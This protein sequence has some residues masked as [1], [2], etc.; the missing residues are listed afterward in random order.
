M[1]AKGLSFW[2]KHCADVSLPSFSQPSTYQVKLDTK[3]KNSYEELTQRFYQDPIIVFSLFHAANQ[4]INSANKSLKRFDHALS[5]LG[6]KKINL[7]LNKMNQ[8][9]FRPKNIWHQQYLRAT[10][11]CLH[12]AYQARETAHYLNGL[13]KEEAFLSSLLLGIPLCILWFHAIPEMR[14]IESLV[15]NEQEQWVDAQKKVLGCSLQELS[16]ALAEELHFPTLVQN[17]LNETHQ[18]S[19]KDLA[20]TRLSIQYQNMSRTFQRND[21]RSFRRISQSIPLAIGLSQ[22]FA[23]EAQWNWFSKRT[24]KAI[25]WYSAMT[26]KTVDQTIQWVHQISASAAQSYPIG[27][28]HHAA[29]KLLHENITPRYAL[30]IITIA[31]PIAPPQK[32]APEKTHKPSETDKSQVQNKGNTLPVETEDPRLSLKLM[33]QLEELSIPSSSKKTERISPLITSNTLELKDIIERPNDPSLMKTLQHQLIHN[34]TKLKSLQNIMNLLMKGVC[35][36][37][38]LPRA[39]GGFVDLANS[40]IVFSFG[41]GITP[42]QGLINFHTS[43]EKH[44]LFDLIIAKPAALWIKPDS[45]KKS[46]PIIPKDFLSEIQVNDFFILSLFVNRS[47]FA[48]IYADR[49]GQ[50]KT[51]TAQEFDHFKALCHAS[52]EGFA[53]FAKLQKSANNPHAIAKLSPPQSDSPLGHSPT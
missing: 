2:V 27:I 24:R 50:E 45:F 32:K 35:Q 52:I 51:L 5:L 15:I 53:H 8:L 7:E 42:D 12:G 39:I 33:L 40:S 22:W 21:E 16:Q 49:F 19:H 36:G 4:G 18:P 29:A 3:K 43:L 30:P 38:G 17:A 25:H 26:S 1:K 28:G 44:K 20:N 48:I 10:T 13:D 41:K 31:E 9:S 14:M 37:I 46:L 11:C 23:F 6:E 47:P 34:P